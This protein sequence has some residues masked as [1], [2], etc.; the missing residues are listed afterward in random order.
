MRHQNR[1]YVRVTLG[2][3]ASIRLRFFIAVGH[4]CAACRGR[5]SRLVS[6]RD[7]LGSPISRSLLSVVRLRSSK[8]YI[9]RTDT[10]Q[11]NDVISLLM[12]QA[13]KIINIIITTSTTTIY[14][15]FPPHPPPPSS[16]P[17]PSPS[18]SPHQPPQ[19]Q[20]QQQ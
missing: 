6:L 13:I 20:Q 7:I 11:T 2:M 3:V 8:K 9:V 18:P 17:S 16:S 10:D 14:H 4:K 5:P 12:G 15:S 1:F 19:Q